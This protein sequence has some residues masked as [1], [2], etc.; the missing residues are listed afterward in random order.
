MEIAVPIFMTYLVIKFILPD[1]KV[2][3]QVCLIYQLTQKYHAEFLKWNNPP[4]IFG[5]LHYHF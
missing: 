4:Y 1:I 5:T 3:V 2:E